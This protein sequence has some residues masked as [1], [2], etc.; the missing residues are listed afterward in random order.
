MID[1]QGLTQ[2]QENPVKRMT[3]VVLGAFLG[4]AHAAEPVLYMGDNP[5]VAVA[6][7][8]L[9]TGKGA[10]EFAPV[11]VSQLLSGHGPSMLGMG[12]VTGC[13][14]EPTAMSDVSA[15]IGR[16]AKAIAYLDSEAGLADLGAAAEKLACLGE[17]L[18]PEV[19]ARLHVLRGVLFHF[20]GDKPAAWEEYSQAF[21]FDSEIEWDPNFPPESQKIF[22][23]ASGEVASSERVTL[24]VVPGLSDGTL[25]VDGRAIPVSLSGRLLF[26]CLWLA[27][28]PAACVGPWCRR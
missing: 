12:S 3:F 10:H 6:Q 16:A 5:N 21:G 15:P 8:V 19:A 4:T 9:A 28:A 14:E 13:A 11:S 27:E 18:V 1:S 22:E 25:L 17:P 23:L 20:K 2:R 7:V 26:C 24:T